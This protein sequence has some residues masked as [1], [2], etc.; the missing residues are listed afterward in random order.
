MKSKTVLAS[1]FFQVVNQAKKIVFHSLFFLTIFINIL[2][3]Q[4]GGP[5]MVTDDPGTPQ[6]GHWEINFSLN[7]DL[8]KQEKGFEI[9][10]LDINYGYNERIQLKVE[11]PYLLT[12]EVPGEYKGRFGDLTLGCK[13]RFLDEEKVGIAVS[14]YPQ[15]TYST[16]TKAA[17]E[18]LFPIQV[19][20]SFGKVVLGLDIRYALVNGRKDYI[21]NGILLGYGFSDRLVVMMEFVY[22]G[23]ARKF[24][25]V[26][27]VFNIGLKYQMSEAFTFMTSMGTGLL[28]S[29]DD[30]KT[31]FIS[32]VGFQ[33]NL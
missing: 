32:F 30:L 26:E 1:I 13:Y 24:D 14:I 23:N 28:S 8:K 10:L 20:K 15:I 9:P 4:S 7:S 16:V 22:W 12:K 5:P 31:T 18:F 3:A 21:Q 25:D 6:K 27:G 33:I 11:F 2:N 29:N 19:E 17:E